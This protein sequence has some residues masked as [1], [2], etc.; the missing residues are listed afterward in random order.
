M[1]LAVVNGGLGLKLANNSKN[2]EIAYGV[3]SGVVGVIYIFFAVFKR[4][5]DG[6]SILARKEVVVENGHGFVDERESQ[7]RTRRRSH[8]RR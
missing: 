1:I 4:K 5:G 8:G 7:R 3:V 6:S 2:G